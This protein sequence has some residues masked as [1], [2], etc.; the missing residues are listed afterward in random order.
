MLL[1]ALL[2]VWINFQQQILK[3][4]QDNIDLSLKKESATTLFTDKI[5]QQLNTLS[6]ADSK[7]IKGTIILELMGLDIQAHILS[8]T[9]QE[10]RLKDLEEDCKEIPSRI[11][12]FT[13]NTDAL[14]VSEE[15]KWVAYAYNTDNRIARHTALRA[16]GWKA[17]QSANFSP[18]SSLLPSLSSEGKA[19]AELLSNRLKEVLKLSDNLESPDL[20][21][22]ALDAI[23]RLAER[24]RGISS[25]LKGTVTLDLI[26]QGM[27][28]L[29]N[30]LSLQAGNETPHQ[31]KQQSKDESKRQ[32]YDQLTSLDSTWKCLIASGFC[33]DKDRGSEATVSTR[34][35]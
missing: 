14:D 17:L 29:Q 13:A 30:R 26:L 32:L 11:A 9:G 34:S 24:C 18:V 8:R 12:L 25:Y 2:T 28:D 5:V 35:R 19:A 7:I 31:L 15:T 16:L 4:Q 23:S 1:T 27:R 20:A 22:D 10:A 21:V 3:S 6:E 33:V